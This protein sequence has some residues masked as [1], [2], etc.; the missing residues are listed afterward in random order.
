MS[1]SIYLINNDSLKTEPMEIKR[2]RKHSQVNLTFVS[3]VYLKQICWNFTM[4]RRLM[5]DFV[6]LQIKFIYIQLRYSPHW[7]RH[8][9]VTVNKTISFSKLYHSAWLAVFLSGF[10]ANAIPHCWFTFP[11][12]LRA[13]STEIWN[14]KNFGSLDRAIVDRIGEMPVLPG[15]AMLLVN[16]VKFREVLVWVDN[17]KWIYRKQLTYFVFLF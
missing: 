8:Q 16:F 14:R 7:W 6:I 13:I 1:A 5:F 11:I 15:T 9:T 4:E 10:N 3:V 12:P 17:N 2:K